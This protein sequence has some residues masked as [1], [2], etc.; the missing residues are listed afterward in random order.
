MLC[1]S[2]LLLTYQAVDAGGLAGTIRPKHTEQLPPRYAKPAICDSYKMLRPLLLIDRLNLLLSSCRSE[3]PP[4]AL[5]ARCGH[6]VHLSESKHLH[7][8]LLVAP[9]AV[10]VC[11][12]EANTAMSVA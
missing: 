12:S 1:R 9:A 3:W 5:A 7:H 6:L 2:K 8:V 4:P 11:G 10:C